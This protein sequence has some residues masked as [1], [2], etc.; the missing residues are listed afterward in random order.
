MGAYVPGRG[1]IIWLLFTP[2][3]GHEQR[4]RRPALVIS[5]AGYNRKVGLAL[6]CPI[7]STVKDYPFEVVL[8]DDLPAHG[9]VLTDQ[10]R[11][12]DWRARKAKWICAAPNDVLTETT[13]KILALVDPSGL[14]D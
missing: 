1:D 3:A 11:S 13:S 8:P 12:L 6:V 2:H 7:T 5:P 10:L 14:V 4:G 9:C